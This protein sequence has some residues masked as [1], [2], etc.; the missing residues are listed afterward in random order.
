MKR[1]AL[2]LIL[3]FAL[4]A[5]LMVGVQPPVEANP[6]PSVP[7]L[8][9]VYPY[10]SWESCYSN[11]SVPLKIEVLVTPNS[12]G[13]AYAPRVFYSLDNGD[14]VTLTNVKEGEHREQVLWYQAYVSFTASST[15]CDLTE[16]NHTLSAYAISD[17]KVMSAERT[18][19]VDSSYKSPELTLI[20]PK[21]IT[22]TTSEVEL[23]FSTTKEL[24]SA[25]YLLDYH[26]DDNARYISINGN[27]TLT[28]LA[29]GTHKI[30]LFADCF[31]EYGN[32]R[33]LY[34]GTSF[35]VSSN[36]NTTLTDLT[37]NADEDS[38]QSIEPT[39]SPAPDPEPFP[40]TLVIGIVV[41]VAIVCIGL[42]VY[43]QKRKRS[44]NENS[45]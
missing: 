2:V 6:G 21:K 25:K 38:D 19:T 22:Y 12:S 31:D 32:G 14:N 26:L 45:A 15:L 23:I 35:N 42:F 40:T 11:A 44:T 7:T 9:V 39:Q 30:I 27:I 43:F 36:E 4:S 5:S 16:G 13:G 24:K 33:S 41:A 3:I 17:G 1:K 10:P 28:N 37:E 8:S 18:F 29:N 34:Q 20:S